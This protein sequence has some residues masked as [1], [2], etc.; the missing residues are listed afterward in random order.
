MSRL[1][2]LLCLIALFLPACKQ[3]PAANAKPS[4]LPRFS[5]KLEQLD[6][7]QTRFVEFLEKQAGHNV[8]L[9]LTIPQDEFSGALQR[10]D[11][12][13]TLFD[14]CENLP[15]GEKP[16]PILCTGTEILIGKP[17]GTPSH[18]VQKGNQWTLK[19]TFRVGKMSGPLQGLMSIRLD[20]VQ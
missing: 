20:P 10:D 14:D 11:D 5:G 1:L 17:A 13:L 7:S 12:F 2:P 9:D 4:G 19:G 3:A 8:E 15:E 18:L 16:R 6:I